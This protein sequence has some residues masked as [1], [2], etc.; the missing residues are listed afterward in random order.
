MNECEGESEGVQGFMSG[1]SLRVSSKI[2]GTYVLPGSFIVAAGRDFVVSDGEK[3]CPPSLFPLT[4]V[5]RALAA[6]LHVKD[7]I[8]GGRRV[9]EAWRRRQKHHW[10]FWSGARR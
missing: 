4:W 9:N 10:S 8:L 3:K 1:K 7:N 2:W 5:S 6:A